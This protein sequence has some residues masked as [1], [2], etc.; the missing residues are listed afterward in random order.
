MMQRGSCSDKKVNRL[1]PWL[2]Q[3]LPGALT[4]GT[5]ESIL[6]LGINTVCQQAICPNVNECFNRGQATFIILGKF[7]TRSCKFCN[8]ANLSRGRCYSYGSTNKTIPKNEPRRIAE[9]VRLLGLSYVVI[10]SVT[11]D[12]LDDGGAGQF[13]SVIES[14]RSLKMDIKVEALVPDFQGSITGLKAVARAQPFVLAHNLEIVKRL[15]SRVRPEADYR[16]SL[17][18]LKR[19]K[20]L[21]SGLITKSSFMLGLGESEDEVLGLMKDLRSHDC[22]IITLGQYLAPSSAHYPVKEFISPEQFQRYYY[23]GIDLGFRKVLSGPKVRSS[24]QAEEL[25]K[26]LIYA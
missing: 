20:E 26:G 5:A 23:K 4:R 7:C 14:I 3:E 2:K 9:A 12:D 15:Y 10:T 19:A 11:R 24:Y 1:P 18:L 25:S 21:N 22:D 6:K 8:I 16:R 17:E 13:E